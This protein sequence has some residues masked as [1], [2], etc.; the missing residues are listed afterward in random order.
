MTNK[1][2]T[3]EGSVQL[4]QYAGCKQDNKWS[5]VIRYMRY[6]GQEFIEA[7]EA[8]NSRDVDSFRDAIADMRV[9]LDAFAACTTINIEA[10]YSE[11]VAKLKTR[12]DVTEEDALMTQKK[13]AQLGVT[14]EIR[15]NEE[16]KVYANIIVKDVTGIDGEFYP[17]GKF[18]KSHK[19]AEPQLKA[20]AQEMNDDTDDVIDG[21]INRGVELLLVDGDSND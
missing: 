12:F 11:V 8:V 9:L 17:K 2:F 21:Y 6:L 5:D 10:D 14:T 13:Y 19:F 16:S 1:H 7:T 15:Y 4:Q 3:P 18:M 20:M